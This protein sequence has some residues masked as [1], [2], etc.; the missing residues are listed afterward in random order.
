MSVL[1]HVVLFK[2]DLKKQNEINKAIQEIAFLSKL[3]GVLSLD[4]A[5]QNNQLY[6]GYNNRSNG[7]THI[8]DITFTSS[9]AFK[10]YFHHPEHVRVVKNFIRPNLVGEN[11]VLSVDYSQVDVKTEGYIGAVRHLVFFLIDPQKAK[12][13]ESKTIPQL[14]QLQQQIPNILTLRVGIHD[15]KVNEGYDDRSQGRNYILDM[16]FPSP[17]AVK[18]YA[19][20]P[21]HQRVIKDWIRPNILGPA[22][23]VDWIPASHKKVIKTNRTALPIA[24][25]SQAIRVGNIVYVSGCIGMDKTG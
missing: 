2:F 24:P 10:N 5:P 9:E 17:A 23:A 15:K 18:I 20:H 12:D 25:Y 13:F 22:L 21:E 4:I 16:T 14:I 11:P 7:Y 19:D 1:R 3:P 6:E 8:L